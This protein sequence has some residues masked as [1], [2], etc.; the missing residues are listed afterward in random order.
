V[1]DTG[2]GIH[3]ED[4]PRVFDRFYRADKAR[5]RSVGNSGLGLSICKSIVEMHGGRIQ[6][7][8]TFEVGTTFTVIL[9]RSS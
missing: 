2:V 8:S 1:S 4:L 3:P 6:A 5:S 7:S 9:P